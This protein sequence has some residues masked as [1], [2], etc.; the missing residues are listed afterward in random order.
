MFSL[1]PISNASHYSY[2]STSVR[3]STALT[4][5]FFRSDSSVPPASQIKSLIG[6]ELNDGVRRTY[7]AACYAVVGVPQLLR[8]R[9]PLLFLIYMIELFNVVAAHNATV[10]FYIDDGQ[11]YVSTPAVDADSTIKRFVQWRFWGFHFFWGARATLS[12][13]GGAQLILS[14]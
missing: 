10:H 3:R 12:S 9:A 11:L 13:G 6:C 4:T 8:A 7:L 1:L 2:C 5:A 14:R